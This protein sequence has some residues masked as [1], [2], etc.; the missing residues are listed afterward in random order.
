MECDFCEVEK[1]EK[2]LI[3]SSNKSCLALMCLEPLK[4]G[5]LLIIPKR[6]VKEIDEL[7]KEEAYDLIELI[8]RT[9]R[10]LQKTYDV[11]T[12][13]SYIK[14]GIAKSKEHFHVHLIPGFVP[15]RQALTAYKFS[16]KERDKKSLEE[17][18]II[19]NKIK[20]NC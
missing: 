15:I 1:L 16:V 14:H 4:E 5:H 17:L 11:E 8:A 3:V 18:V 9:D 10:M 19:A 2:E 20:S 13:L 12:N 6:H 7:T